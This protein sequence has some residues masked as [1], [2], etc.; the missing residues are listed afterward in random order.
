MRNCTEI[1]EN[2]QFL[3]VSTLKWRAVSRG[4][5]GVKNEKRARNGPGALIF[6]SKMWSRRGGVFTPAFA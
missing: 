3:P 4:Q 1:S 6:V 2:M 5:S